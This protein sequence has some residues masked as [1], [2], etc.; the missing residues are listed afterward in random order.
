MFQLKAYV[1]WDALTLRRTDGAL[2]R[3]ITPVYETEQLSDAETRLQTFTRG[4]VPVLDQFL[5]GKE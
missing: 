1:F 2:V 5:P 4:L 3:L